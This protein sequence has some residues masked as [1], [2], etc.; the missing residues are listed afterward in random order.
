[1][2]NDLTKEIREY[3]IWLGFR[4]NLNG[5]DYIA[6]A[7]ELCLED[8]NHMHSI[9]SSLYPSVARLH[10]TT[11]SRVERSI[12]HAISLADEDYNEGFEET[13]TPYK[14]CRLTNSLTLYVLL[15]HFR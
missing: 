10:S 1:M 2:S 6:S 13:F 3:L 7:I 11:A 12:R 14:N 9:T 15:E 4:P 5:F 8:S